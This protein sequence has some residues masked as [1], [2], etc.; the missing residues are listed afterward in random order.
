MPPTYGPAASIRSSA[1]SIFADIPD[2]DEDTR[3][4]DVR[5][6]QDRTSSS[7]DSSTSAPDPPTEMLSTLSSSVQQHEN[8]VVSTAQAANNVPR[9]VSGVEGGCIPPT[10]EEG[11]HGDREEKEGSED[12]LSDEDG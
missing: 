7:L 12:P 3:M 9:T 4:N 6:P 5:N 11:S 1:F 2:P 10:D 8:P